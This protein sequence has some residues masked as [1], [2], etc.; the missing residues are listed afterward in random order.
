MITGLT[1]KQNELFRFIISYFEQHGVSPSYD[2]MK[3]A[4]GLS[5]KSS[6]HRLLE[7]LEERGRIRRQPGRAR[8]IVI[9]PTASG[10]PVELSSR[11][12]ALVRSVAARRN[13]SPA[14]FIQEAVEAH[15][16]QAG[17]T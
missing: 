9:Q 7:A 11:A 16:R 10:F 2:E 5:S 17:A 1:R 8:A 15:L 14:T 13:V 6:I 12:M 3:D 4:L